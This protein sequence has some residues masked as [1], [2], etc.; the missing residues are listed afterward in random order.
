MTPK[1]AR[2]LAIAGSDSGGGAGI[3]ADIKTITML[4]GHAMTAISAIT[5]QNSKGVDGVHPVPVDMVLAQLDAVMADYG[6]DAIKIGMIGSAAL[7][8]A[9]AAWLANCADRY[10]Q[11]P[12]TVCDPVM[13]ASSGAVLADDD[14][15]KALLK[16]ITQSDIVTPNLPELAALGGQDALLD[17]HVALL[18]KGGHGD[19][20]MVSDTLYLSRDDNYSWV[21]HR[22]G[23][24]HN[25]GT[26][27]T[28]SSA[29]ATFVGQGMSLQNAVGAGIDFVRLAMRN[30]PD[31]VPINGAMGH[32]A[33][34]NDA[35][36][37][38]PMMNQVT[39]PSDD[40]AAMLNFY[41]ALGMTQIVDSPPRYARFEMPGGA[42]L[43]I[44]ARDEM[45]GDGDN[46]ACRG[47]GAKIYL[48]Y[49]DVYDA[50]RDLAAQGMIPKVEIVAQSWG[51]RE[52]WIT[53]PSGNRICLYHAGE[54]RR[55]PNWRI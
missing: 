18:V 45:G 35:V 29:I 25:H 9:L 55:F 32:F 42:T 28:L 41:R 51:W 49:R 13:V 23:S 1:T 17:M 53:D 38:G 21:K 6:A 26:G 27:C 44:H 40:Y 20:N 34:R 16:V 14:T 24:P 11:R 30:A 37:S 15:K 31:L 48:E 43:S 4:G 7:A 36:F 39:L 22:I 12:F 5:A 2:I 3:Q 47:A 46:S 50:C 33:V 8:E 54:N 10:G 19:G 52:A